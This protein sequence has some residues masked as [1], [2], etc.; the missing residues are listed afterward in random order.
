M[1][2]ELQIPENYLKCQTLKL[3]GLTDAK[4][5]PLKPGIWGRLKLRSG[6][7]KVELLDGEG[8]IREELRLQG[9][10]SLI[11]PPGVSYRSSSAEGEVQGLLELYCHP[12][13][14]FHEKYQLTKPHS[15]VIRLNE[16]ILR[17]R[18]DS[19]TS[20]DV[21]D[22][23]CGR[24]RNS[25]YLSQ[26]GHN[27]RA[28]DIDSKQLN[29]LSNIIDR[30][31]IDNIVVEGADLEQIRLN[32][33]YD[34]VLLNVVLQFLDPLRVWHT[35][36]QAQSSTR[37][38]GL[39]LIVCPIQTPGMSWPAHFRS[40]FQPGELLRAYQNAGWAIQE[41]NENFGNLHRL[42]AAGLPI[43]GRFATLIAQ[44]LFPS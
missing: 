35:L 8:N 26:F 31:T 40:V 44:K 22:L 24:G 12:E 29:I 42:D 19:Q 23:G 5:E 20:L 39:H 37:P 41:Y 18:L 27:I 43:R 9:D 38:G 7:L 10:Q 30:E 3:S 14:Y 1:L 21:L 2:F 25:L 11:I 36:G 15:E 13:H 16:K 32:K 17:N 4:A 6:A 33:K 34:L 28:L